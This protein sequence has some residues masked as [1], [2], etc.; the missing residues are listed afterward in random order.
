M[1]TYNDQNI[2]FDYL[3]R[4]SKFFLTLFAVH[5]PFK[6]PLLCKYHDIIL[7]GSGHYS[8][9]IS[10]A[11]AYYYPT[12][13]LGFNDHITW[14]QDLQ[15]IYYRKPFIIHPDNGRDLISEIDFSDYPLD[16][17]IAINRA[18]DEWKNID[19]RI[20]SIDTEGRLINETLDYFSNLYL[21]KDFTDTTFDKIK[22]YIGFYNANDNLQIPVIVLNYNLYLAI[23]IFIINE[24]PEFSI[25]NYLEKIVNK[26]FT[27]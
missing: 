6:K 13:G 16:K 22:E 19:M 25:I 26:N 12:Y 14:D 11:E 21:K 24:V 8:I 17:N 1:S 9:W 27:I 3:V 18:I 23:L 15:T 2:S 20:G 4:E 7:L 10:D 5:Y